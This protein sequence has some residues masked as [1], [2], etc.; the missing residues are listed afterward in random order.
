RYFVQTEG[1]LTPAQRKVLERL[2]EDGTPMLEKTKGE[3]YLVV[4]RL[5]TISPW[6]SK[7]TDIAHNC[8]L[9]AVKRI[10]RGTVFYVDSTNPG[11]AGPLHDRMTQAVLR[12]FDEAP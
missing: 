2:L 5:G 7:A 11:I 1:E 10:E 12:S 4:P 6:S 3:V 8:G 9:A